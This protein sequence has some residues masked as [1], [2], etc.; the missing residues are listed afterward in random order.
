[1]KSKMARQGQGEDIFSK[2][3]TVSELEYD[4]HYVSN[5]K[6]SI[7]SKYNDLRRKIYQHPQPQ[8][9][10]KQ[11]TVS[12]VTAGGKENNANVVVL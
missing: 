3:K 10:A 5:K 1:M 8:A 12:A 9:G 4:L 7:E 2:L 6:K 11:G